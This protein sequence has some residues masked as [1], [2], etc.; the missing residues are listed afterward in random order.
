MSFQIPQ[1][2][3]RY[4]LAA[5][6]F[7]LPFCFHARAAHSDINPHGEPIPD[8]PLL[9]CVQRM[10]CEESIGPIS[11]AKTHFNWQKDT[12]CFPN[13]TFY[14]KGSDETEPVKIQPNGYPPIYMHRCFVLARTVI[15]FHKFVRFDPT[16]PKLSEDQY[17]ALIRRI[18]RIPTWW[19][20]F[21]QK[22]ALV[23]PGYRNLREFSAAR[24]VAFQKNIGWWLITYF[25][26]GNWR[27][28]FTEFPS[29]RSVAARKITERIDRGELQAVYLSVFPRMNHCV[30]IYDY[31]RLPNGDI[32]FWN[33][34]PNY[35]NAV[36]ALEW[37]AKDR[38]FLEQKRWFFPGGHVK[39]MRAFISPFH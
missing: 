27:M 1:L 7:L 25:R 11:S 10:E 33:Y 9:A 29:M 17:E 8:D 3:P 39:L 12:L 31:S 38:D 13:D 2:H 34:D 14:T 22:D 21:S 37:D 23:V 5:C 15:E 19:P 16:L 28:I 20:A 4:L 32:V 30:V 6:L 24:Q 36:S 26:I 35:H 18:C